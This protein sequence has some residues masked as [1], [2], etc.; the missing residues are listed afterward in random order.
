MKKQ[1]ILLIVFLLVLTGGIGIVS[2]ETL[3]GTLGSTG[4][5]PSIYNTTTWVYDETATIPTVALAVV[6]VGLVN[7]FRKGG[8][9]E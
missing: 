3:T 1:V 2:A 9:A 5:T 7:N 4:I 8:S 6:I